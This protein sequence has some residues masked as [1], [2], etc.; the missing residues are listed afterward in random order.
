MILTESGL[1]RLTTFSFLVVANFNFEIGVLDDNTTFYF[2]FTLFV[3]RV[4]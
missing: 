2:G 3:V 1:H 4:L